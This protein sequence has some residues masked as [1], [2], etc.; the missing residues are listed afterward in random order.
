M[1]ALNSDFYDTITTT[2][3]RHFFWRAVFQEALI[4]SLSYFAISIMMQ[5][6]EKADANSC[7]I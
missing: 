5:D 2:E 6:K 1:P 4:E 7:A 3:K